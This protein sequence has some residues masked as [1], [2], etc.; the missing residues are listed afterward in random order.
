M[1]PDGY[2]AINSII[3]CL[4]EFI[5]TVFAKTGSITSGT[6]YIE[7]PYKNTISQK[8]YTYNKHLHVYPDLDDRPNP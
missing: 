1:V 8:Y 2:D 6:G 7:N 5:D 4:T 3:M